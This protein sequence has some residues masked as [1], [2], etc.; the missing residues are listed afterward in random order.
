MKRWLLA[1]WLV[2]LGG[3]GD[4]GPAGPST[5][6]RDLSAA[7]TSFG[8]VAGTSLSFGRGH[9]NQADYRKQKQ[10]HGTERQGAALHRC[11]LQ[12]P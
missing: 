3:C 1:L 9:E 8:F 7:A 5:V 2:P 6:S 10:G 11:C 4:S 12:R